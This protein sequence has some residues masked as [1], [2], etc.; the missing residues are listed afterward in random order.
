MLELDNRVL[1]TIS[2]GF[3]ILPIIQSLTTV[4]RAHFKYQ[5]CSLHLT[6]HQCKNLC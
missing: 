3:L 5:K 4:Y 6:R 2:E 1:D